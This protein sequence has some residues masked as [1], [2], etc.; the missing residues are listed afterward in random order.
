M[1]LNIEY[2]N[3]C[4]IVRLSTGGHNKGMQY[5]AYITSEINKNAVVSHSSPL[6]GLYRSDNLIPERYVWHDMCIIG[7][8]TIYVNNSIF[9]EIDSHVT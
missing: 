8:L 5:Y 7:T 9:T 2:T 1:N 6:K 3:I 4:P